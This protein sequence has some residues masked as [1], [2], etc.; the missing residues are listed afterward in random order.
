VVDGDEYYAIHETKDGYSTIYDESAGL[1]CYAALQDG[2]FI[3]TSVSIAEK[4]PT[5]LKKHLRESNDVVEEKFGDRYH[6]FGPGAEPFDPFN[7]T[8][9]ENAG[10][11]LGRT[12][13]T[14]NV[15]GLTILVNFK[16]V[17]TNITAAQVEE[18]LNGENYTKNGNFSSVNKYF[19]LV[20]NG[21][22]NYTNRVVGPVTLSKKRS[23]YVNNS[24][25]KEALD[26][27][28]DEGIDLSDFDSLDDGIVDS[29]IFLYAGP[30]VFEGDIWP[31]N[32]VRQLFFPRVRTHFYLLTGLGIDEEDLSIGTVCHEAGHLLCRF[33]DMYD[34]GSRDS[35]FTRSQGI[36][37]YCLMGSGNHL[38][39]RLTPS[40]VCSY[41]RELAGWTDNE[42]D[43]NTPGTYTAKHGDYNTVMKYK[44]SKSNEYFLVENRTKID[45]DEFL[46]SSGLAVYHCD[47]HGSNEWQTGT[48][49]RHYQCALEQADG[50]QDL[51]KGL[52][53]GDG[54]DLFGRVQ[55]I[56]FSR[57]TSPSSKVW[58]GSDSGFEISNISA[59]GAEISFT[60]GG[61][62][63]N[64]SIVIHK[65][66]EPN[67]RIP[68]KDPGGVHSVLE[69]EDEGLV[70]EMS[71]SLNISHTWIGDLR[72]I[73]EAPS[74]RQVTLHSQQGGDKDDIV[75]TVDTETALAPLIGESVTGAWILR[76][77]D[78][79]A[80]D[81]GTLN[82]WSFKITTS[83]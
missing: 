15:T 22:L 68:D 78:H 23:H 51:E 70:G 47:I 28:L 62:V 66:L 44:T 79:A 34:Y 31:H 55:G 74:G 27:A 20:S 75:T 53:R 69:V 25:V 57:Q 65:E 33:P 52:N 63:V 4:A 76:L 24:L 73:L 16:D 3:S 71:L 48:A 83:E 21:K 45:L 29:L 7:E 14:G 6:N 80:R 39:H 8:L 64:G 54:R 10:L 60:T 12:L 43:L 41:L 35:D 18:M 82:A 77:S 42:I 2:Q 58:D 9:G 56:A 19:D 36:G 46:P 1:Y 32:G 38:N 59:P 13:H 37:K 11:L 49:N 30:S 26:L 40:P 67:L 81:Q 17:K 5:Y 50:K 61:G 72:V